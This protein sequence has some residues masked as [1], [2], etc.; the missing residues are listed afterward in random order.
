MCIVETSY[1]NSQTLQTTYMKIQ[2]LTSESVTSIGLLSNLPPNISSLGVTSPSIGMQAMVFGGY[3]FY[4]MAKN[5]EYYIWTY[6]ES[7]NNTGQLGPYPANKYAANPIFNNVNQNNLNAANCIMKN[8]NFILALATNLNQWSLIVIPLPRFIEDYRYGNL[9]VVK[10]D[11]SPSNMTGV[12]NSNVDSNTKTLSIIF[13]HP[14]ILSTGFITI[15]KSSDNTI[16][17]KV[18]AT[19]NDYVQIINNNHT[20]VS[21]T[22]IGSTFNQHDEIYYVQMDANFVRDEKLYEPL[23][24]IDKGIVRYKSSNLFRLSIFYFIIC[25]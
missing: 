13:K 20:I 18:Q 24:G 3:I 22:I 16:R 15:Y 6:D 12:D 10:I 11:P 2:F 4:A 23:T 9:Q 25:N 8:N 5:Q 14:V 1:N 7:N 21:V 19:M 17:Q